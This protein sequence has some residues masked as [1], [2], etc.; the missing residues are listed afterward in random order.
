ME[1]TM[2]PKE[3]IEKLYDLIKK[4]EDWK[5]LIADNIEFVS[6]GKTTKTKKEYVEPKMDFLQVVKSF[7]IHELIAEGNR[8]CIS[9]EYDLE[10]P[11]THHSNCEVAEIFVVKNNK[12]TSSCTFFNNLS[13]KSF[14]EQERV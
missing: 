8:V 4:K 11:S 5:W 7:K 1:K 9:V 14:L 3:V 2:T 12:I 6:E 10:V 13:F